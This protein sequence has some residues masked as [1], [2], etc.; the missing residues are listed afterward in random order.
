MRSLM[1]QSWTQGWKKLCI[2]KE[3]TSGVGAGLVH[4]QAAWGN[5]EALESNRPQLRPQDHRMPALW[6]WGISL[7]CPSGSVFPHCCEDSGM[8]KTPP[9]GLD[10]SWVLS[11]SVFYLI[12]C[13]LKGNTD[14]KGSYS[15]ICPF[16][17]KKS[18]IIIPPTCYAWGNGRPRQIQWHGHLF[19]LLLKVPLS[20][21][22]STKSVALL[23]RP[24]SGLMSLDCS[25]DV[26]LSASLPHTLAS[27]TPP[28]TALCCLCSGLA[29]HWSFLVCWWCWCSPEDLSLACPSSQEQYYNTSAIALHD[30]ICIPGEYLSS[31]YATHMGTRDW[32]LYVGVPWAPGTQHVP[33]ASS[34]TSSFMPVFPPHAH[35][36]TGNK[37][38]PEPLP[39]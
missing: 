34:P 22:N 29:G 10:M 11:K 38:Q 25:A 7:L 4:L 26:T 30:Q 24:I 28:L 31:Q 12:S 13:A 3:G 17:W 32:I 23:S 37:H 27:P 21:R 35:T 14:Y 39:L 15:V 33:T 1:T 9:T 19:T 18:K 5:T 6:L 16:R 20:A 2:E 36:L 8:G